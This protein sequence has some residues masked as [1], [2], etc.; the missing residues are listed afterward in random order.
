[1]RVRLLEEVS[2]G[3]QHLS[4]NLNRGAK[5]DFGGLVH[6]V[7]MSGE[8]KEQPKGNYQAEYDVRLIDSHYFISFELS[9]LFPE[10]RATMGSSVAQRQ[11]TC[12]STNCHQ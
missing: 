7:G 10:F 5:C 11:D 3:R 12:P 9:L 6:L 2:S 4:R 1:M 8:F